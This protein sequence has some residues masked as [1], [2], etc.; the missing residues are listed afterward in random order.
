M[1]DIAHVRPTQHIDRW[2][3][4]VAALEACERR[5][6]VLA[7]WTLREW[8]KLPRAE[9]RRELGGARPRGAYWTAAELNALPPRRGRAA[10]LEA[11]RQVMASNEAVAVREFAQRHRP[12]RPPRL[13]LPVC[14]VVARVRGRRVER[15]ARRTLAAI[16]S[17]GTEDGPPPPPKPV[18]R[19]PRPRPR[20]IR[21]SR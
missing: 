12:A 6:Q 2:G 18:M 5:A 14:R 19:L 9:R 13:P 17:A 3:Y 8:S 15:R 7:P 10:V 1:T 21:G 4:R 16:A 20:P 11:R